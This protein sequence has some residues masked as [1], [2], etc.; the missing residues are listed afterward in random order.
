MSIAVKRVLILFSVALNIGFIASC[1]W[2]Y[3][4][5][6]ESRSQRRW[7]ELMVTV[8]E[9]KLG[10]AQKE[11]TLKC[12]SEFK[13][14][15]KALKKRIRQSRHEEILFLA[16]PASLDPVQFEKLSK[17]AVTLT[18]E[19]QNMYQSHVMEL[20]RIMGDE[21]RACFFNHLLENKEK[22]LRKKS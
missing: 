15:Y 3:F 17:K 16:D 18:R 7:N 12:L 21:Q 1:A 5:P 20:N 8:D 22:R 2:N 11:E 9:L 13:D 10:P 14:N 4:Q 19:K 6:S